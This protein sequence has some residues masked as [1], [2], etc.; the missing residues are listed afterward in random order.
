M[1]VLSFFLLSRPRPKKPR[2]MLLSLSSRAASIRPR[3]AAPVYR[4]PTAR[5]GAVAMPSAAG[6]AVASPFFSR[7]T[8]VSRSQSSSSSSSSV[9]AAAA[10][11]GLS[12]R[13]VTPVP[14][15]SVSGSSRRAFATLPPAIDAAVETPHPIEAE[16]KE[17]IVA[18]RANHPLIGGCC[19]SESGGARERIRVSRHPITRRNGV[20]DACM[21]TCARV[22]V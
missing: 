17:L 18:V 10:V 3:C 16:L 7:A 15:W 19:R 6:V 21:C 9:A 5:C 22:C 8:I 20:V 12:L 2:H 1:L 11:A 4:A 13:L 14:S